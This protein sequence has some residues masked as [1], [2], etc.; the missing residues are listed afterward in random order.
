MEKIDCNNNE[1]EELSKLR[2]GYKKYN[3]F[4]QTPEQDCNTSIKICKFGVYTFIFLFFLWI[5]LAYRL[6]E[7]IL[8][9]IA[10]SNILLIFH[11]N[12]KVNSYKSDLRYLK[13]HSK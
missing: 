6:D 3:I 11:Y 5:F 2:L 9:V 8:L 7:P 1:D 12:S 13:C 10:A 4:N